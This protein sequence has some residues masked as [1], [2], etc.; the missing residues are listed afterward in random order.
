MLRTV[1]VERHGPMLDEFLRC[2]S[3]AVCFVALIFSSW[4]HLCKHEPWRLWFCPL[5]LDQNVC[6]CCLE[7]L[8]H[9]FSSFPGLVDVIQRISMLAEPEL[10]LI[11]GE[12]FILWSFTML[13]LYNVKSLK[14][15]VW[16]VAKCIG[17]QEW[18]WSLIHKIKGSSLSATGP[19]GCLIKLDYG[20]H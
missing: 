20:C 1:L 9:Y 4:M 16:M 12:F 15:L 2:W 8:A 5:C 17:I 19:A 6:F 13:L 10:A 3:K 11:C 14:A 18:V 7:L